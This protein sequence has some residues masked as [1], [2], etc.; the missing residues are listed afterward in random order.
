MYATVDEI[1]KEAG[2]SHNTNITSKDVEDVEKRAR[3]EIHAYLGGTYTIP[4]S[5]VP[6]LV[7]Q[8]CLQLAAGML[9]CEQYGF[10]VMIE[11]NKQGLGKIS[12]ARSQLKR[13]Q[14]K[15]IVIYSESGTSLLPS[16]SAD[17]SGWPDETTS[18]LDEG[19]SGGGPKFRMSHDF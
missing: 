10:P 7:N 1:K 18:S 2:F 16:T 12:S 8:I 17:V 11:D 19:S 4:F 14:K 6:P 9:I 5:P 3:N 13:I 15:E